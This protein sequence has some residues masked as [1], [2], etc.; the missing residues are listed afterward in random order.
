MH[1]KEAKKMRKREGGMRDAYIW[2]IFR[3]LNKNCSYIINKIKTLF[4]FRFRIFV[5]WFFYISLLDGDKI[6]QIQIVTEMQH[7]YLIWL[8]KTKT[9][10]TTT[11]I[12]Y[13]KCIEDITGY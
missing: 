5:C 10:T 9:T 11:N 13:D 1:L 2:Y 4:D 8:Q 6:D 3:G 12:V 7:K